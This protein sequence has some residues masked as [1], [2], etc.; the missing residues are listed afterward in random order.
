VNVNPAAIRRV[1]DTWNTAEGAGRQ[2]EVDVVRRIFE[3]A[4]MIPA[5][6]HVV[7]GAAAEPRWRTVRPPLVALDPAIGARIDAELGAAGFAMPGYPR[8]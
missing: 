4:P 1:Y 2:A 7:A 5:M 6:K 8:R 3:S